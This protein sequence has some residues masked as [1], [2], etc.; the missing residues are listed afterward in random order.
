[1][2]PVRH[3]GQEAI[4]L[5]VLDVG[6]VVDEFGPELVAE[7][8]VLQRGDRIAQRFRQWQRFGLVGR[9][10]RGAGVELAVDAVET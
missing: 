5:G 2:L 1:M 4:D 7:R 9:V 6:V 8:I 10:R 3:L